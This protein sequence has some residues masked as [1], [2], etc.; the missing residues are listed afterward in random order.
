VA[1]ELTAQR[2]LKPAS[3]DLALRGQKAAAERRM[4]PVG[5]Q[6]PGG[7]FGRR[8]QGQRR[9]ADQIDLGHQ[10]Q[11]AGGQQ[12]G[13]QLRLQALRNRF[14]AGAW[15]N[16]QRLPTRGQPRA[17]Q[18]AHI[19]GGHPHRDG[20]ALQLRLCLYGLGLQRGQVGPVRL[21][22][23][24][25][26]ITV[27]L[28]EAAVAQVGLRGGFHVQARRHGGEREIAA[29][30]LGAAFGAGADDGL[31][32]F[33]AL[34]LQQRAQQRLCTGV[35]LLHAL[36]GLGLVALAFVDQ[37]ADACQGQAQQEHGGSHGQCLGQ[38]GMSHGSSR[39]GVVAL[40]GSLQGGRE[41]AM[42]FVKRR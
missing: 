25:R 10:G 38:D 7:G 1:S 5:A 33:A 27:D 41:A 29:Q 32:G 23:Q 16:R 8:H 18:A 35:R 11:L 12:A 20:L 2:A 19:A 17:A 40:A 37:K 15:P 31:P 21:Q 39:P 30:H 3:T 6:G 34:A 26:G 22:H 42:G 28:E 13:W 9:G 14:V 24:A 36:H 4:R